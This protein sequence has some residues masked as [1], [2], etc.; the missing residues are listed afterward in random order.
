MKGKS[1]I[2]KKKLLTSFA[3]LLLVAAVFVPSGFAQRRRGTTAPAQ[4]RQAAASPLN[5]LPASDAV[6]LIDI[7]R[8]LN[9]V[10]PRL[11]AGDA[12]HLA[13]LN[14]EIDK[15]KTNYG[16]DVRSFEQ[17]AVGFRFL[18][19]RAGVTTTDMVAVTR[20]SFNSGALLAAGRIAAE[21][22][23]QEEK[24][25]NSTI[26]VFDL[27]TQGKAPT[28]MG[29]RVPKL[30]VA[31]LDGNTLVFGEPAGV[32]SAIDG[33]RLRGRLNAQLIQMAMSTPNAFISFGANVPAS[34]TQGKDFGNPE[35]NRNISAIRQAYGAL[36]LTDA[37][38]I[39][40]R[41]IAR[42][43]RADQAKSLGETL[44]AFK[45]FGGM[46]VSQL[47]PDKSKLAQAALDSVTITTEG[48]ETQL[49]LELAQAII[50]E[51]MRSFQKKG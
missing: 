12:A 15:L 21:G 25:K 2:V 4:A 23:Y 43:E 41:A 51:L 22:K 30:A 27:M 7:K 11:F 46:F 10:A 49:K 45:Q 36:G 17:L 20:G 38:G 42:T 50:N 19:P 16:L 9:D 47:P 26:Y 34:L 44:A 13:K 33:S 5:A 8:L 1:R 29:A 39:D 24:Y 48:N 35:I 40:L 18:S 3:A 6:M 32:R 14:A 37:G 31:A 28:I